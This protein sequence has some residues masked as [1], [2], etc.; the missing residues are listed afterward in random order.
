MNGAESM[1]LGM[2]VGTIVGLLLLLTAWRI[3]A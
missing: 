1:L 3:L 2:G